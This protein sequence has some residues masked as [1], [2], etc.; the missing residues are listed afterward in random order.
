MTFEFLALF[1][2]APWASH[3][4]LQTCF[5]FTNCVT[6]GELLHITVLIYID[7]NNGSCAKLFWLPPQSILY[8]LPISEH[9][10]AAS[11][12]SITGLPHPLI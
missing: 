8:T 3:L 6:L 5:A 9:G 4:G 2:K 12:D 1:L 11:L 10:E 7:E